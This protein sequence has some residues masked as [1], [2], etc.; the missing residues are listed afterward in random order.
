MS[1]ISFNDDPTPRRIAL[2]GDNDI[3]DVL[4]LDSRVWW[5]NTVY[6]SIGY[7]VLK[8]Y[9]GYDVSIFMDTAY[10]CLQFL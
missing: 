10:P 7:G 2:D 1:R 9:G 3:F 8:V 6:P 5:F 4:S